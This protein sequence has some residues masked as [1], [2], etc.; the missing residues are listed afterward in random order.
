MA[1]DIDNFKA[2]VKTYGGLQ[3][4]NKYKV[5]FLPPPIM[6]PQMQVFRD[7]EFFAEQASIPGVNFEVHATNRYGYGPIEKRV[8]GHVFTDFVV[9]FLGDGNSSVHK[10]MYDW[11]SAISP[12]DMEQGI[13]SE[14]PFLLEYKD[15]YVTDLHVMTYNDKGNEINGEYVPNLAITI[16]EAF[17]IGISDVGLAWGDHNNHARFTVHFAYADWFRSVGSVS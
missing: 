5:R 6:M 14:I 16:R 3:K 17:P 4:T 12:F 8:N 1:F 9:V 13:T 10:A 2:T 15:K 11:I 7:L